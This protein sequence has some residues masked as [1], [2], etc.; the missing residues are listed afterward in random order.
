VTCS[1]YL[2]KR[3]LAFWQNRR[4]HVLL[5]RAGGLS[6]SPDKLD[7]SILNRCESFVR[8]KTYYDIEALDRACA[9]V[10]AIICAYSG[11]PELHLGGQLLLLRAAERA[12]VKRY[13]AASHNNNWQKVAMGDVPVYD[14]TRMF[15]IQAALTSTIKPLHIFSG[16]F[17]DVLFGGEGQGDFTP[18]V[19]GVWDP[20]TKELHIWGTGDEKW[21]FTTEEDGGKWAVELVVSENAEEGGFVSL[22]SMECS[23]NEIREVYEEIR[24][25]KVKVVK[26]GS[27]EDLER[28]V[29]EKKAGASHWS[30]WMRFSFV[31]CCIKGTWALDRQLI[32][33]FQPS[34]PESL[35]AWLE[36]HPHD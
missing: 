36:K 24:G 34:P 11:T 15:H 8:S 12:G 3:W 27:V 4:P 19:G 20:K 29:Q 28:K 14:P 32:P 13:L 17:L 25:T 2:L 5:S 10:D 9:G 33:G 26:R 31:L 7:P 30:D 6:R 21:S 23:L 18:D 35:K 22:S 16:T 1:E